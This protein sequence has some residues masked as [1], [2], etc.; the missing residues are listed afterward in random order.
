QK[1][2]PTFW[3]FG[4]TTSTTT[5]HGGERCCRTISEDSLR[6]RKGQVLSLSFL[7]VIAFLA[8]SSRAFR[9]LLLPRRVRISCRRFRNRPGCRW[10]SLGSWRFCLCYRRG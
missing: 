9:L 1:A 6:K 2:F 10:W 3:N 4:V 5:G 8:F 7:L